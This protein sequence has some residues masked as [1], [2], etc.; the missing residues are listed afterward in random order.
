[1]NNADAN[2]VTLTIRDHTPDV[3]EAMIRFLYLGEAKV[4][5]N[6]LVDLLELCQE[7]L[8]T[9]MKQAIEHIFAD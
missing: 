9:G 2:E 5:S 3:F 7:Y 1:M 6:D 4:N 8:L